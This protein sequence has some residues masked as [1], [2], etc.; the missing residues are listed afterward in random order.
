M[1]R[2]GKRP[3]HIPS[4]TTVSVDDGRV[5]VEGP[6]GS[7]SRSLH[8]QIQIGVTD[9]EVVVS[10]KSESIETKALWGTFASHIENMVQGVNEP[11]V[12]KLVVDGVGYRAETQGDDL[13]INVGFSHPIEMQI[14]EGITVEVEKN[15][16]TVSGIDK[17]LVG[18]FAANIRA[19]RE[20]EPYKGKGI[21]YE[22]EEILRKQ[23]KKSV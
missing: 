23:G 7:L 14:P 22:D 5:T 3:I 11:Y 4:G 18:Q 9:D 15:T 19:M 16:I 17:D 13:V 10:R 2:I 1:S 12:K 21:R 8:P 6:K 20:P